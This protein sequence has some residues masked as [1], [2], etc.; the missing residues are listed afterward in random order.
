MLGRCC[1]TETCTKTI[2]LGSHVIEQQIEALYFFNVSLSDTK[3]DRLTVYVAAIDGEDPQYKL[4]RY[5]LRPEMDYGLGERSYMFYLK[6]GV[7]EV[8]YSRYSRGDGTRLERVR[9]IMILH[10]GRQYLYPYEEF[11]DELVLYTAFNLLAQREGTHVAE[12]RFF[13]KGEPACA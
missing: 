5:F 2:T 7:Y 4:R 8:G 10:D 13:G 12:R 11:S 6:N 3:E 1:L 9:Y